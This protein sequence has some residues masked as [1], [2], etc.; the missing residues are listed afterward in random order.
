VHLGCATGLVLSW[1]PNAE[2][3]ERGLTFVPLC[4]AGTLFGQITGR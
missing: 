1:A 2:L 4:Y 3:P